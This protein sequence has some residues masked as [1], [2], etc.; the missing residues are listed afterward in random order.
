MSTEGLP[1]IVFLVLVCSLVLFGVRCR[2][3]AGRRHGPVS[4]SIW[5]PLQDRTLT[6]TVVEEPW[7]GKRLDV[8]ECSVLP[9][10]AAVLCEK[11]CLRLTRRPRPSPSSG[12]PVF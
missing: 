8:L 1:V 6:A 3:V 4:R 10:S 2:G 11:P 12:L 9:P 5:C 7:D